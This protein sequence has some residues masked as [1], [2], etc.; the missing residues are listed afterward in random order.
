MLTI[1]TR[2]Q[3]LWTE[4]SLLPHLY[5]PA[6]SLRVRVL[7]FCQY[8]DIPIEVS[9]KDKKEIAPLT[10]FT[11]EVVTEE[12][13]R[14]IL[15]AK[16]TKPTPVQ[17]YSIPICNMKRDLMACAQTGSGKTAGPGHL[18]TVLQG[19]SRPFD[20]SPAREKHSV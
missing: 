19:G 4:S 8:D 13:M 7:V 9:D 15:L 11:P 20:L 3:L 16:F 18:D 6:Q 12:L 17:R 1:P 14:N 5:L 2:T 10:K